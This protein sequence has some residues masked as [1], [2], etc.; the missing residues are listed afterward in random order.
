MFVEEIINENEMPDLE[1]YIRYTTFYA[2]HLL[3]LCNQF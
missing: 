1:N 2:I 3:E